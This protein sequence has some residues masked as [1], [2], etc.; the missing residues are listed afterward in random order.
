SSHL[1]IYHGPINVGIVHDAGRALLIDCGDGNLGDVLQQLK[2][3]TIDRAIFTHHHR[4]QACGAHALADGGT[5]IGVPIAEREHFDNVANFWKNPKSRWHIYNQH[6][7]HL[8]LAE[9]V[10]VD[11]TFKDGDKLTWGPA[12]IR[13]LVTPGHTDGSVTY[14]VEVDG[15]RIAFCGDVIYD[16]G[17]VWDL[18]SLQKGITTTD[19]HGF[20]GARHEL[21]ESLDRIRKAEPRMLVPSHGNLMGEPAKAID[22][23]VRRLDLCY[24]KYVATSA[25]RHYFPQMFTEYEGRKDHMPI[26]PG[27]PVPDCLRHFG[28]TWML[29]SQEKAA[30]V[31]DC[32]N[33]RSVETIRNA[34]EQGEVRS[35]EGLWVTHY[36]D[37]HVD[38][39]PQ[40]QKMFDCPCITDRH[41]ARVISD[42]MAW[43]LPCISP[44]KARVDRMTKDSETWRW[45]EFTLTAYHFPGQTL[46]HSG[47][48]VVG[49]GL[50]M[51]FAGDSFTMAGMD[52]YCAQNRNWLGRDV[53]FDR[54]LALLEQLR[55]THIFNCH[56]DQAFTFTAE[57]LAF[58]RANLAEREKLFGQLLPW[59]HPNQGMED[60]WVRCDPYEQRAGGGDDVA[61]RVIVRNHG[62]APQ[63]VACRVVLPRAWGGSTDPATQWTGTEVSGKSDGQLRI[64]VSI[65]RSAPPG[66][67]VL[68]IDIRY[69]ERRLPQ[70]TEAIVVV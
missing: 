6:P 50:R 44:S 31:M 20:L 40:F 28:T 58:M 26:S 66:R 70:F 2:I 46:Y 67:Y 17:Q 43:R 18:H 14:V 5:Q 25:L 16:E 35:V 38:A 27:K 33:A 3:T 11:E 24:D 49:R 30:L 42:P 22:A 60:C 13:V 15:Q 47:L 4:D 37:D 21:S 9:P 19:Y 39:I 8:M 54:C 51:F 64:T 34:V 10:R 29:V 36:H 1:S 59:E 65:P 56:V 62:P 57:Q 41:V 52:D 7:H 48:F 53:G 12:S 69:G 61:L 45:H 63:P 68:P 55:P 32:G 23:L